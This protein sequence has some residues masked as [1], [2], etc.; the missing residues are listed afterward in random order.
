M[1]DVLKFLGKNIE[2]NADDNVVIALSGGPDSMALLNI[3]FELRKNINFNIICAHVNHNIREES[4]SEEIFVKN[5]CDN[6]NVLFET[7][8]FSYEDKFSESI[9]HKKRYEYFE[10]LIK[11]YK[12][13][14]LFTAHHGDDLIETI[15]MRIV[16]GSSIK[17]YMGFEKIVRCDTYT[18]VRP[19]VYLTKKEILEYNHINNI[20]YVIDKSND[21]IKYTRNRYRKNILPLLKEENSNVHMKFLQYSEI[22]EEYINYVDKDVLFHYNEV[23]INNRIIVSKII[24][25]EKIIIRQI[26]YKWLYS[27]YNDD[28]N[29]INMK[30]IN[31]IIDLLFINKPNVIIDIPNYKVIKEYDFVYICDEI[32]NNDYCLMLKDSILLPNGNIIEMKKVSNK[33]D[34]YVTYINSKN[35]KLPLYVRNYKQGDKMTIKNFCGHKKIKDIFINEKI[36]VKDRLNQPVVVDSNDNIIWLPGIKKSSFDSQE[37]GKYDIILEYGLRKESL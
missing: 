28:I 1:E 19:L 15:L 29:I 9:G 4:D 33:T 11:K 25:L 12:A 14:Y 22:L 23:I 3:L 5:Y 16:R 26:I 37:D 7:I 27:F 30:H 18:I 20:P 24:L 32:M 2:L 21:D 8:K 6:N 36:G 10:M 34:N 35:I 17:G 13:K 31:S